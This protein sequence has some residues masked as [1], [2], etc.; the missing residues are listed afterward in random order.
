MSAVIATWAD[1]LDLFDRDLDTTG[2]IVDHTAES[3]AITTLAEWPP[4]TVGAL[5]ESLRGR[6]ERILERQQERIAQ[7][8]EGIEQV[9]HQLDQVRPRATTGRHAAPPVY[10]D[11][12]A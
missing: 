8:Q 5:P 1:V 2:S 9:R 3:T 11:T 12:R 7:L 6:A 10:I 4:V